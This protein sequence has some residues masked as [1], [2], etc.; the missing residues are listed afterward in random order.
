M[1]ALVLSRP[2]FALRKRAFARPTSRGSSS[3]RRHPGR[4][5]DQPFEGAGRVPPC[6][7]AFL[8]IVGRLILA[9]Q[10]DIAIHGR[11]RPLGTEQDG[12]HMGVRMPSL[13]GQVFG[14]WIVWPVFPERDQRPG[15]EPELRA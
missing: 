14:A 3:L 6:G 4:D 11:F 8:S 15:V 12:W 10:G 13:L 9:A 5:P 1:Q 2:R 7:P